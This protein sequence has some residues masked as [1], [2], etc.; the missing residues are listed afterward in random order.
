[1]AKNSIVIVRSGR[2]FTGSAQWGY[3][4]LVSDGVH[5]R[6]WDDIAGAWT[7]VHALTSAQLRYVRRQARALTSH[8]LDI[9]TSSH[10]IDIM[11]KKT[12]PC[13]EDAEDVID[14]IP[15]IDRAR[16][17]TYAAAAAVEV[18]SADRAALAA[19]R[20]EHGPVA[21]AAL[22]AIR[23]AGE[24]A[25][26][27]FADSPRGRANSGLILEVFSEAA[28]AEWRAKRGSK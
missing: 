14:A 28:R 27:F 8:P 25:A 19:S 22:A 17:G 1:M 20:P 21:V 26:K 18:S 12:E 11:N 16:W 6:V 10:R 9:G 3:R 2:A 15:A 4:A 7:H 5:V 23:M 24:P 13:A